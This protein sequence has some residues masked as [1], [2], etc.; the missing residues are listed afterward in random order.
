[1]TDIELFRVL[2]P[3]SA[4]YQKLVARD[5]AGIFKTQIVDKLSQQ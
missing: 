1:M 2:N 5:W 3:D 4:F